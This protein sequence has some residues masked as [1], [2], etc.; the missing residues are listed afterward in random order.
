[1]ANLDRAL[2]RLKRYLHVATVAC[3][4]ATP[5]GAMAFSCGVLGQLE[6]GCVAEIRT[7][8]GDVERGS[9]QKVCVTLAG[10]SSS[11]SGAVST[12]T[13]TPGEDITR[14]SPCVQDGI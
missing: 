13:I 10:Q 7:G 4:G 9:K 1:M 8:R 2:L 14:T 3:P 5:D 12:H 11:R 6:L